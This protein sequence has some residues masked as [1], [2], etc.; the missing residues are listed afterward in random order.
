MD[1]SDDI[2]AWTLQFRDSLADALREGIAG[3][4]SLPEVVIHRGGA[5]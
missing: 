5:S 2:V 3:G 1:T 4:R